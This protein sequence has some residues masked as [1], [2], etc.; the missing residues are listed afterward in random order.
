MSCFLL[1]GRN[2]QNMSRSAK[3][4]CLLAIKEIFIWNKIAT[5]CEQNEKKKTENHLTHFLYSVDP[6]F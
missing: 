5:Q 4:R 2:S 3:I 6:N 1:F